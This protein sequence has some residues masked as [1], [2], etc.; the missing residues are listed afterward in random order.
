MM[1]RRFLPRDIDELVFWYERFISPLALIGGFLADNYIL[2]RRVD[3]WTTDALFGFYLFASA[4][5]I[6]FLNAAEAGRIRSPRVLSLVPFMPVVIQFSIGG[7]FSG[8][9]S[10]YSRSAAFAGSWVFVA[11][12]A[13]LLLSNE[14]FLRW[15]RRLVF[16]VSLYFV[17]LYSFLIFFLPVVFKR[18]GADMFLWSGAVSG[19]G[20]S[21][22]VVLIYLVAPARVREARVNLVATILSLTLL[23]NMLYFANL[24]PPLPLALKSGG[25]YHSV[26]HQTDGAYLLEG[27][28]IPWYEAFLRYNL[29][30]HK[31]PGESVYAFTAIFAPTGLT[32]TIVHEWQLYDAATNTWNTVADIPFDITGGRDG[33]YRG[34]S[35]K[36]DPA[37]GSWRVNV[38]TPTGQLIT[39]IS[40][41]VVDASTSPTLVETTL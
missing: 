14:R 11:I 25:L 2:L 13:I 19:V 27:E 30:F 4:A 31:V 39:R 5:A 41:T 21:V 15:Y 3:L 36:F 12:V 29:T 24:I 34:W 6:I 10:L 7:L 18:I 20:I 26:L 37:P 23:F 40:F 35:G 9:L 33:G 16:Q 22:F 8:F 17:V 32:T 38:L 1:A 28:E